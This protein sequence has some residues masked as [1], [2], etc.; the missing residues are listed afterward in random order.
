MEQLVNRLDVAM[1]NG[2]L[3]ESDDEM[4]T[5]PLSDPISDS[6]VLPIPAGKFGV[7]GCCTTKECLLASKNK[8]GSSRNEHAEADGGEGGV[9]DLSK[10]L[11]QRKGWPIQNKLTLDF[12]SYQNF[13]L[14]FPKLCGVTGTAV[15]EST[16][17]ES[18][19][20]L[21]V[22]TVP[23]N[24]PMI[25]K[26]SSCLLFVCNNLMNDDCFAM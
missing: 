11:K 7:G 14:Q 5:D 10:Q 3:W 13:F 16:K 1:F 20:K 22:S 9:M 8:N 17:F 19:H 6:K 25:R 12:I 24:K 26:V 21:K 18:I 23:T 2:I 15:T 4:L